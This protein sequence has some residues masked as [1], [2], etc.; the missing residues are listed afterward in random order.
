MKGGAGKKKKKSSLFVLR[1][2]NVFE[3][4]GANEA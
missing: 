1:P 4:E 2:K 3:I